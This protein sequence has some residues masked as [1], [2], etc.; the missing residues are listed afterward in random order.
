M[1][2]EKFYKLCNEGNGYFLREGNG[3]KITYTNDT[4]A[5]IFLYFEKDG[6]FWSITEETTGGLVGWMLKTLEDAKQ[7]A[8]RKIESIFNL[9]NTSGI[10]TAQ[11]R[12]TELL[13]KLANA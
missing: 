7:D 2:K 5:T 4:H 1:K 9:M 8:N 13:L 3:Y 10:K 6:G 12:K 11:K